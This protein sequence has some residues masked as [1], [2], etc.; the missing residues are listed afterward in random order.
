MTFLVRVSTGQGA[1]SRDVLLTT[2]ATRLF[3]RK[4]TF[5]PKSDFSAEKSLI[6]LW[7]ELP[8]PEPK[9]ARFILN[10]PLNLVKLM[11]FLT[12][13]WAWQGTLEPEMS[14]INNGTKC[15]FRHFP[16]NLFPNA[17]GFRT[18]LRVQECHKMS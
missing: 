8:V 4:V 1:Q 11:T 2:V 18:G 3:G 14:L 12:R 5:R 16:A 6:N 10:F 15:H 13:L 9:T 17:R 7:S